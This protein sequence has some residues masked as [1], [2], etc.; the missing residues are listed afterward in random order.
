MIPADKKNCQSVRSQI[1]F[2]YS[3][4]IGTCQLFLSSILG[5]LYI[6]DM[7]L[8]VTICRVLSVVNKTLNDIWG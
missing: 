5:T 2:G 7:S 1:L 8:P 3:S 4:W 6:V